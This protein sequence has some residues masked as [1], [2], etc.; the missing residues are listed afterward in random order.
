MLQQT[1]GG[2]LSD[3]LNLAEFGGVVAHLAA[4]AMEG[5]GETVGLI[6]N[7]LDEQQNRG[8]AVEDDGLVLLSVEIE[9][10]LAFGERGDGL[11]GESEF[12][13]GAGGGV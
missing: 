4:L 7:L 8:V 11:C 9:S 1:P 10:L 13:K 2:H 5:D 6:A 3:A 12:F